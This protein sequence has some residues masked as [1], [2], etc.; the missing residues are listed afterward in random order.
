MATCQSSLAGNILND[1]NEVIG[2]GVKNTAWI[3]PMS[4]VASIT[5][6]GNI[7]SAFT[8][9]ADAT[10][11]TAFMP[12][13]TP[14]TGSNNTGDGDVAMLSYNKVVSML[15]YAN[16][17][18]NSANVKALCDNPHIIVLELK[19][20]DP[21]KSAGFVVIGSEQGAYGANPAWNVYE[22]K[23]A[24]T[25]EMTETGAPTPQVFYWSGEDVATTRASLNS[26]L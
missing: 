18:E 12:G 9:E 22:N 1:C 8:L 10:A 5:R 17:P 26:L 20:Q 19:S 14:F 13:S 4:S 2:V 23:G 15:L 3:I 25:I 16:T 24:W 7:I 11:F 21:A 6:V